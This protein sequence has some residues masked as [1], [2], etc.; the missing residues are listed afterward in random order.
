M[1]TICLLTPA[2][3]FSERTRRFFSKSKKP[4]NSRLTES[5]IPR[6]LIYVIPQGRAH[7]RIQPEGEGS[8]RFTRRI[9]FYSVWG[10]L[11]AAPGEGTSA[12]PK[13]FEP[14]TLLWAATVQ[15]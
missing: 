6:L 7:N 3:S 12:R 4:V 14:A 2:R 10:A 15:R 11:E 8:A 1:R 13:T 9:S 5:V